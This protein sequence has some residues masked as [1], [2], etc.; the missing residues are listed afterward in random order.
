MYKKR[1]EWLLNELSKELLLEPKQEIEEELAV[2][3]WV[4]GNNVLMRVLSMPESLRENLLFRGRYLN[5]KSVREPALYANS[6]Y[7]RGRSRE[8]DNTIVSIPCYSEEDAQVRKLQI[9]VDLQLLRAFR[10]GHFARVRSAD[11]KFEAIVLYQP[12][13][14]R[15]GMQVMRMPFA[16]RNS[17]LKSGSLTIKSCGQPQLTRDCA[18]LQGTGVL[19]D[20]NFVYIENA[21]GAYYRRLKE[22]L[23]R[24]AE[25]GPDVL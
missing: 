9:E 14:R 16:W 21:D 15:V 22:S 4:E 8:E 18:Y 1:V 12:E 25:E 11:E 19:F 13:N 20:D 17:H 2:K 5:I 7:L 6:I 24:L 3:V 23:T 10:N